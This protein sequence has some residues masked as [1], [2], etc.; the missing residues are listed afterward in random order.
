M[1]Q[2]PID[3]PEGAPPWDAFSQ[4]GAASAPPPGSELAALL[5]EAV[6]NIGQL[7]ENRA[8]GVASAARRLQAHAHYLEVMAV[9][10]FGRLRAEQLEASKA[11]R[12][13]VRSRDAEYAA[14]ELGMEMAAS[15]RSAACCS[16]WPST[17]PAGSRRPWPGWRRA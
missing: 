11:R 1:S 16:T 3:G 7:G 2:T 9:A 14:E 10:E 15:A 8:L 17:S 12:D 5:G 4:D 6:A 13:R